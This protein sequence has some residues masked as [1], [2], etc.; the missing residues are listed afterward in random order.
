[1]SR[2][3]LLKAGG[4]KCKMMEVI[5]LHGIRAMFGVLVIVGIT[6]LI[7]VAVMD[8]W[9]KRKHHLTFKERYYDAENYFGE[10]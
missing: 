1:M 2:A 7:W 5:I 10:K 8:Y 6:G 9:G 3:L 4:Q